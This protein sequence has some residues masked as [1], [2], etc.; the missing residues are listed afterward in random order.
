MSMAWA[1]VGLASGHRTV[2]TGFSFR[3]EKFVE[4]RCSKEITDQTKTKSSS[5]LTTNT[6]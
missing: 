3:I 2:H 1:C 6:Q 5:T 4:R